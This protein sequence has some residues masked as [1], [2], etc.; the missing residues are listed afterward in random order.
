[1]CRVLW[2]NDWLQ[3]LHN[4]LSILIGWEDKVSSIGQDVSESQTVRMLET[5]NI[6]TR[7]VPCHSK[8]V[9]ESIN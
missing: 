1:M 3:M 2:R 8:L 4:M 5:L 9:A 6:V 7:S